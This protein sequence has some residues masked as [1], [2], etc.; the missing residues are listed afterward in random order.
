[1]TSVPNPIDQMRA[2]GRTSLRPED[3]KAYGVQ[4]FLDEQE[5][6]GPFPVP[7]LEFTEEENR[8]MDEILAEER[9]AKDADATRH[10]PDYPVYPA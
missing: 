3:I 9:R 1:M 7:D 2:E 6:L 10:Q 4:R 8:L 5:K